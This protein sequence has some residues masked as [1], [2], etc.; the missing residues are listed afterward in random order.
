MKIFSLYVLTV[1]HPVI[2]F[3]TTE[4]KRFTLAVL[5]Y[6]ASLKTPHAA[7]RAILIPQKRAG[8]TAVVIPSK[9]QSRAYLGANS[10]FYLA[11]IFLL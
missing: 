1:F 7:R 9:Y 8:G 4:N 6:C 3:L 11:R 5:Y 2:N 10:R